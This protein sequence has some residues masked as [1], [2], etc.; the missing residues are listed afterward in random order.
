MMPL[1]SETKLAELQLLRARQQMYRS[2]EYRAEAR[3]WLVKHPA[4]AAVVTASYLWTV[5]WVIVGLL[6]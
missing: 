3:L 1:I 5:W 6:S 2:A 4:I